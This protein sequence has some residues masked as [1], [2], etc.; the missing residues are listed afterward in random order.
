MPDNKLTDAKILGV[1]GYIKETDQSASVTAKSP[2]ATAKSPAAPADTNAIQYSSLTVPLGRALFNG[3]T[4][5][6]N[7]ASPCISCHNIN[8]QSILGG[9]TLSL[10]L[11]KAFVKLGPEGIKAIITNPP[12]P[13]MNKALLTHPLKE[14]EKNAIISMLKSVS[15]QTPGT[16]PAGSGGFIF[17]FLSAICAL[18]ILVH[19]YILYDNGN[20]IK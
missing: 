18:M 15:E 13:V 20:I 5:F 2:A 3:Y 7:G 16:Q 14:N 8:N 19:I 6:A 4:H 11:T 9:G 12:F 10:N 1:I 17:I